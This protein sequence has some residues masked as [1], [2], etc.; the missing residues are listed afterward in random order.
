MSMRLPTYAPVLLLLS[1]ALASGCDRHSASPAAPPQ[2]PGTL[3]GALSQSFAAEPA[4]A[5]PEFVGGPRCAGRSPFSVRV[6]VVA[7]GRSDVIVRGIRFRF[8]DAS[9]VTALPE[10]IPIPDATTQS[11]PTAM[12]IPIPGAAAL[13]A[14]VPIPIPGSGPMLGVLVPGGTSRLLRFSL[15]F[16]CDVP[17]DGTLHIAAAGADVRG[18]PVHADLRVRIGR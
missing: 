14:A 2:L 12:P 11:I 15:R 10:V 13:P 1:L 3:N 5:T 4:H 8:V 17:P 6:T 16:G 18:T 7:G 9:G